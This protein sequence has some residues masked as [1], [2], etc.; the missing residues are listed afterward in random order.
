MVTLCVCFLCLLAI[1]AL[2]YKE[3]TNTQKDID[4]KSIMRVYITSLEAHGLY[5]SFDLYNNGRLQSIGGNKNSDEPGEIF[6]ED[7]KMRKKLNKIKKSYER[8]SFYD[9]QKI[10]KSLIG[11]GKNAN[12]IPDVYCVDPPPIKGW[13]IYIVTDNGHYEYKLNYDQYGK[14][15]KTKMPD[16]LFDILKIVTRKSDIKIKYLLKLWR[17]S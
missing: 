2:S 17:T 3:T 12:K 5:Y 8:L 6:V 16:D 4:D 14:L 10:K 1:P 15:R 7:A 13:H 9:F 11:F